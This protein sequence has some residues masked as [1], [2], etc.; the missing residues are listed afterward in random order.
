MTSA[1]DP[2]LEA[3]VLRVGHALGDVE[4]T[5][6]EALLADLRLHLEEVR[7]SDV[8]RLDDVVGPPEVYAH[9]LRAAAGLAAPGPAPAPTPPVP[10]PP[11]DAG[12]AA[13]PWVRDRLG[14][15]WGVVVRGWSDVGAALGEAAVDGPTW[16]LLRAYLFT[17]A[18]GAATGSEGTVLVPEVRDNPV[19]GLVWLFG[20]AVVSV[21]VGRNPRLAPLRLVRM[22]NVLVVVL[23]VIVLLQAD[24]G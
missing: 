9:E 21:R 24:M 5:E 22:V 23:G 3:Y 14:R 16:W 11:V 20:A 7:G 4:P 17:A 1:H 6:R 10:G 15:A 2:L 19:W 18:L 12:V 13:W 8:R